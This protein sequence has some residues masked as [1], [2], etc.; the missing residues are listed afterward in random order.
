[1]T[2]SDSKKVLLVI[3]DDML[4]R[5]ALVKKLSHEGYTVITAQR[6]DDAL[7]IALSKHPDLVTLDILL[8]DE[9][10]DIFMD[11]I[12]KD[13]WGAKVPIIVLTN[14]D[15]DNAMIDKISIDHPSYYFIKAQTDM[16]FLTEKISELI[17]EQNSLS[18]PGSTQ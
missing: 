15:A 7:A 12:R 5:E 10:G 13:P 1:M 8:P 6:G 14:F 4:L 3:E 11:E 9:R 16:Q 18:P 17:A 2:S